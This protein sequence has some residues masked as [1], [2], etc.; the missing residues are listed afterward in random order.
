MRTIKQSYVTEEKLNEVKDE[1]TNLK[2][3][4]FMNNNFDCHV[5]RKRGGSILSY[6]YFLDSG[7]AGLSPISDE[8]KN[9][10]HSQ[11]ERNECLSR[12]TCVDARELA[13]PPSHEHAS[14][15]ETPTPIDQAQVTKYM[16]E[17]S[18]TVLSVSIRSTTL[19]PESVIRADGVTDTHHQVMSTLTGAAN[20]FA[21]TFAYVINT[22][23]Q[24]K[25]EKPKE[26]WVLVQ[27][28]KF[29][30]HYNTLEGKARNIGN[31]KFKV[32]SIQIKPK[33]QRQ[34]SCYKMQ[35]PS[36][37]LSLFLEE[38]LWPEGITVRKFFEFK[39]KVNGL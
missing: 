10:T 23:K 38:T 4:S 24:W 8:E 32:A 35:V 11:V 17:A 36:T 19:A 26:Q 3:A 20:T 5:N 37:K 27:Q 2:N 7:P 28:K 33:L 22:G 13:E 1:L 16:E 15:L 21:N 29:K 6:S 39:N 25:A 14:A 12:A 34:Y 31:E 30:N 18:N 9:T